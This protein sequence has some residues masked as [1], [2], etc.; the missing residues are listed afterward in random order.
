MLTTTRGI[1]FRKLNYG[2][3][4]LIVDVFT[5]EHG[6]MSY[7]I[8]GVRT[9]KARTGSALLQLMSIVE[10]VAYH[11][12]KSKLHRIKEANS[13]YVFEHIP[14]NIRKNA[15]ILFMSELCTKVIRQTEKNEALYRMVEH[16]IIALDQ[17]TEHFADAHLLFMLR[18][19]DQLGFGPELAESSENHVFNLLEGR[20]VSSP[21]AHEYYVADTRLLT[22]YLVAA[23]QDEHVVAADRMARNQMLDALLLYYQLHLDKMPEM[24]SHKVL[25]EIL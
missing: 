20:F 4:S 16:S 22:Q 2:E 25:R 23:R 3:T 14:G 21:P 5:L 13:A 15:I 12:E 1:V 7:I 11:S 17:A 18:L 9:S 10:L 6:L 19:A 8:G 24:H